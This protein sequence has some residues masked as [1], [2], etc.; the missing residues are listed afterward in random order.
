MIAIRR[1][2]A[3]PGQSFRFYYP[4]SSR[5]VRAVPF[6]EAITSLSWYQLTDLASAFDYLGSLPGLSVREFI[7]RLGAY[8]DE[9]DEEAHKAAHARDGYDPHSCDWK[10]KKARA[11][12]FLRRLRKEPARAA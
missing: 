12:A 11:K 7:D 10:A 3:F 6:E 8:I 2:P 9:T 4:W 5:S 1:R